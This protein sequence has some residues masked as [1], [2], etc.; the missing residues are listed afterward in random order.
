[1][2]QGSGIAM[3]SGVGLGLDPAW[4][5]LWPAAIAPIQPLAW[6]LLALGAA[7][8]SRGKKK[9][10]FKYKGDHVVFVFLCVI[11]FI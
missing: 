7:L 10:D 8:K 5:C 9:K 3:S 6:E 1:M 2:C 4:L 11:Y